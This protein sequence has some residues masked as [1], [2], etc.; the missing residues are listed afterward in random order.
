MFANRAQ[1]A[2]LV[3]ISRAQSAMMQNVLRLFDENMRRDWNPSSP[4]RLRAG[5]RL[6][7][8]CFGPEKIC[9]MMVEIPVGTVA[10]RL[11]VTN[12]PDDDVYGFAEA[13]M[14]KVEFF[15][16]HG[17]LIECFVTTD[18]FAEGEEGAG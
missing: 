18:A 10:N 14:V 11:T 15:D 6:V 8:G 2:E 9:G 7:R 3:E 17:I 12:L 13:G 5:R 1:L 16:V 4:V